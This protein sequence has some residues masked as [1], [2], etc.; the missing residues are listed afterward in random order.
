MA[1]AELG[2]GPVPNTTFKCC[3]R[4]F[5]ADKSNEDRNLMAGEDASH[6]LPTDIAFA[7]EE[8]G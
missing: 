5:A 1:F 3:C 7:I 6:Q 4:R 2:Y 8:L